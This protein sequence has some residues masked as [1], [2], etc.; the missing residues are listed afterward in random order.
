MIVRR[1]I[2]GVDDRLDSTSFL[3]R[4]LHKVFPDHWSFMLG[5]LTLYSF[6]LLLLTGTFLSMFYVASPETTTYTGPYAPMQGRTVS[7][8]YDSVLRISFE[9]RAG[10]VMR[11]THHWSALMFM[12]AMVAHLVR[13]FFTGAFRKPREMSWL[14]GVTMLVSRDRRRVHRLFAARRPAVGNRAR[15]SSTRRCCRSR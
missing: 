5:E 4:S 13:V 2:D 7:L 3:R 8:A 11:Q 15:A 14:I 9:V 1:L 6:V 10:L 12:A